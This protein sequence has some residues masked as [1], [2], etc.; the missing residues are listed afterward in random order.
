MGFLWDLV[1]QGQISDQRDRSSS[2]EER[3]ATLEG[4]LQQTRELVRTLIERLEAN[5]KTDLDADGKVG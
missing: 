1:Q 4:D 3:V 5:L 2:L